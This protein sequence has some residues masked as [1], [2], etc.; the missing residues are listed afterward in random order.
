[1]KTLE[2]LN[3][4]LK[5]IN[6]QSPMD[7]LFT[8]EIPRM[9]LKRLIFAERICGELCERFRLRAIQE[10]LNQGFYGHVGYRETIH[11]VLDAYE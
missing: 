3:E 1:M 9:R 4:M 6:K 7:E 10:A 8:D 5:E 2:F 11:D